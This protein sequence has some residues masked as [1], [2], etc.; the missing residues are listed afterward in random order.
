MYSF[1]EEIDK[2]KDQLTRTEQYKEVFSSEERFVAQ[3]HVQDILAQV[4]TNIQYYV[5]NPS[6]IFK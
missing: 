1:F 4:K 6:K 2:I 5:D 3:A